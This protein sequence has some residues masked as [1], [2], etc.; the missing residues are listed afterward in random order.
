MAARP[1][2]SQEVEETSAA[3]RAARPSKQVLRTTRP[4]DQ[5]LEDLRN[6][7]LAANADG[8]NLLRRGRPHAA[9][10]NLKYA[11]AVLA[12][13]STSSEQDCAD[14]VALTCSNLGCY[15]QGRGL[16]RAA[17]RYLCRALEVEGDASISLA[18]TKLNVCVALSGVGQ[19]VEAERLAAEAIAILVAQNEADS[20]S[21]GGCATTTGQDAA[22]LAIACHNLG[23]EREFLGQWAEAA[24]AYRQGAEV[25]SRTLGHRSPLARSLSLSMSQAFEKA[26]RHPATPD[27]PAPSRLSGQRANGRAFQDRWRQAYGPKKPGASHYHSVAARRT[28]RSER[29]GFKAEEH[30]A[31]T[32]MAIHSQEEDMEEPEENYSLRDRPISANSGGQAS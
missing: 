7:V 31:A 9:L 26:E 8:L 17:L 29:T 4:A 30:R 20:E 5:A 19:H 16:P 1:G 25:A 18:K 28:W 27:R 12:T 11:E 15:Y 3:R 21:P 6:V 32:A 24:M 10:E 23:A 2:T 13:I 22:L 14:L